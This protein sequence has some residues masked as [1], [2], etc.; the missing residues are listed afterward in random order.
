MKS[1]GLKRLGMQKKTTN[2]LCRFKN[3]E[4]QRGVGDP[5]PFFHQLSALAP[6]KKTR[7][8]LPLKKARIFNTKE[9][10]PLFFLSGFTL[11]IREGVKKK[12]KM[13]QQ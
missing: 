1:R 12:G 3:Y 2:Q 10:K 5:A 7:R 13:F 6:S 11:R 4:R 8:R 9:H